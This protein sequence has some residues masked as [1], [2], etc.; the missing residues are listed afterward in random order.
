MAAE[1]QP[2]RAA[3]TDQ[4]ELLVGCK[5]AVAGT[6]EGIPVV[7]VATGM[8]KTNAAQALT[9][10]LETRPVRGVIGFGIAGAYP[11]SGLNL[12]DVVLASE[13]VY[14]DEGSE[15]PGG[16]LDS[17]GIGI[18]LLDAGTVRR[19]NEFPLDPAR[20]A[21]AERALHHA[22]IPVRTGRLVSVSACA[23]TDA[24]GAERSR[25]FA[26]LCEDM[27]TA[28]L[29]HVAELYQIP[30]LAVRGISNQVEDRNPARWRIP[31]AASAAARAAQALATHWQD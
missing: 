25:R 9:A 28:A 1:A 6:L 29:A 26:P 8:G 5:P 15:T 20:V 11:G 3:L 24:L 31:E 12:G 18:P 23:G 13:A 10:L 14:G 2:L 22:G 17:R 21:A 16:W 30:L 7:I 4:A 27:E 19:F